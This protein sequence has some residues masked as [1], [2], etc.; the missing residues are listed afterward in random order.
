MTNYVSVW[1]FP[2]FEID[3]KVKF[4]IDQINSSFNFYLVNLSKFIAKKFTNSKSEF[5]WKIQIKLLPEHN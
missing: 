5:N 2:S 1:V 3:F 4:E